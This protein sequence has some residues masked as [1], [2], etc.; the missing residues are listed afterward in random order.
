VWWAVHQVLSMAS[1]LVGMSW[2]LAAYQRAVR[3]AQQ[4]KDNMSWLG[5]GLQTVYHL[6]LSCEYSHHRR[7]SNKHGL[8]TMTQPNNY[9]LEGGASNQVAIIGQNLFLKSDINFIRQFF[10]QTEF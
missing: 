4:D 2:C 7:I 9:V 3:F 5:S 10:Y 6:L 1:S 8:E